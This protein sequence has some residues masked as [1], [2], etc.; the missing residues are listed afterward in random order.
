MA[1]KPEI[2]AAA[3]AA[4]VH[5]ALSLEV[6][7]QRFKVSVGTLSRWKRDAAEKGDDWDKARSAARLSGQGAEAVT[8]AVLEDF[9]LLFQSA[10]SE[11]KE[12]K[13]VPP[14]AKAQAISQLS[15][16]YAKTMSAVAKGAPKLNKL[17]VAMEVLQ[18]QVKFIRDAFPHLSGPF[19]DML[20]QFGQKLSEAFG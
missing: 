6:M 5:E 8:T 1:H 17:A 19:A 16:A 18:F 2:R 7:A 9:V 15:D 10:L 11:I 20:D 14:L 3:R 13:E 12:T 4:Y